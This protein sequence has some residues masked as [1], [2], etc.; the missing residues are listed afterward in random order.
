MANSPDATDTV[1]V[2]GFDVRVLRERA[3]QMRTAL[4]WPGRIAPLN[5]AARELLRAADTVTGHTESGK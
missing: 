5:K 2:D 1:T 3:T 4:N